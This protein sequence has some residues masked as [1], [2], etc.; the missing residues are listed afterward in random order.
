MILIWMIMKSRVL[1]INSKNNVLSNL[2]ERMKKYEKIELVKDLML[3][4]ET[5]LKISQ[6]YID[7]ENQMIKEIKE[8]TKFNEESIEIDKN[9][10]LKMASYN[11]Y[12]DKG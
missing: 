3:E 12:T 1:L 2:L 9:L 8:D 5:K 7:Q 10:D 6:V 11:K 4:I